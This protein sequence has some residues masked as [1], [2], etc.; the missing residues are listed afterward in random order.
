LI[1]YLQ[2]EAIGMVIDATHPFAAQMSRNA[3]QAAD[4]CGIPRV[5]FT[6]KAWRPL[7][8]DHWISVADTAAA[9]SV[10]GETPRRVFLTV[11]RLSLPAFRNAP[12]HHYL[13]RSIDQPDS[14]EVPPLHRLVLA[15]G[16]FDEASER[17]LMQENGIDI[18]VTK[19]S[20]G[21]ATDAKIQAARSLGLPVVVIDRPVLPPS[22]VVYTVEEVMAFIASHASPL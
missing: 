3:A 7:E 13:V 6:R 8:G 18:L 10:L 2:R 9:V 16:P 21:A 19:N 17:E 5:V 12:H 1:A 22:E 14:T 20:G 11:G 4:A 15:R